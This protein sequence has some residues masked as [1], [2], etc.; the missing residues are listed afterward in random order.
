MAAIKKQSLVDQI[1]QR[2]RENI[3][4]MQL[5]LGS[6]L[7]VNELQSQM[8]VSCTP[9]REAINRLQQEGLVV[10]ENNVGARVLMLDEHDVREI[11][12]LAATLQVTAVRLALRQGDR[13]R[14]ALEIREQIRR[15]EQ[16]LTP[17]EEVG[18]VHELVGV[19][20]HNCGNKRLDNSMIAIQGQQLL[21]RYLY[22]SCAGHGKNQADFERIYQGVLKNDPDAIIAALRENAERALPGIL[23]CLKEKT[24]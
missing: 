11:Q 8:G 17:Q 22:C 23:R 24:S 5:P 12:E 9:I 7:N 13:Q 16:A 6:H 3:I 21:L 1:Y 4:T 2:L 10:Y 19:F 20:Y 14:M 18:A 15:Y